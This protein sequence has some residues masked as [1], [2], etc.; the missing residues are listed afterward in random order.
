MLENCL[1]KVGPLKATGEKSGSPLLSVH[2][3][4]RWL[5]Q[6]TVCSLCF[7]ELCKPSPVRARL[8]F[9]YSFLKAS[10]E[11]GSFALISTVGWEGSQKYFKAICFMAKHADSLHFK[12]LCPL[13]SGA[14]LACFGCITC[15]SWLFSAVGTCS[16]S[17]RTRG[18]S[19]LQ[20][21]DLWQLQRQCL[22]AFAPLT[23]S[24][25]LGW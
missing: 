4:L 20:H 15:Q 9:V 10:A 6:R 17:S 18:C 3:P 21:W 25:S 16:W 2:S 24:S 11:R 13:L 23:F 19:L 8:L 7:W 14:I 22:G 12:I 5:Q 1:Q